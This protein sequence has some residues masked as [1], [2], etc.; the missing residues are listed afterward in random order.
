LPQVAPGRHLCAMVRELAPSRVATFDPRAGALAPRVL[1]RDRPA[2]NEAVQ[3]RRRLRS[4]AAL[5][6]SV[7][8][9]RGRSAGPSGRTL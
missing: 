3:Q 7:S 9:V 2:P 4:R 1:S 5:R 8:G 6:S